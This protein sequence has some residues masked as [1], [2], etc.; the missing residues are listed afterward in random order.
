[1]TLKTIAGDA[2]R[3][4]RLRRAIRRLSGLPRGQMP[5]RNLIGE[6]LSGWSNEGYAARIEYIE[7][8][9]RRATTTPGHILE[10]GSG[11]TT[12]LLGVLAGSRGKEIWSLEHSPQW[13]QRIKRVLQRSGIRD[14]HVCLSP[15]RDYGDF[16]WYDPPLELMPESFSLVI[17]DGPPGDTKGGRYGLLPALARRRLPVGSIILLDDADRPAETD[18]MNRWQAEM[19]LDV[20]VVR[21]QSC[22]YAVIEKCRT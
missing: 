2:F 17:C 15:L 19:K 6:L 8:V 3:N 13:Y 18:V 9:A 11:I 7:E 22:T 14:D 16:D 1:M 20:E 10:C 12:I 5:D 4:Y 21:G